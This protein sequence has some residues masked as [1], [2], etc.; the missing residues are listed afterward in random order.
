MPSTNI[1]PGRLLLADDDADFLEAMTLA[2]NHYGFE[3]RACWNGENIQDAVSSFNPHIILLDISMIG[4][5]GDDICR[6]LRQQPD[7]DSIPILMISGNDD[8]A[9]VARSCNASGHLAKPFRPSSLIREIR[10]HLE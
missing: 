1:I 6:Q 10:L 8:I 9:E 7:H 4:V 3:V 5:R 2:L